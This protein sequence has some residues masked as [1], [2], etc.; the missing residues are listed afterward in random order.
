MPTTRQSCL[1]ELAIISFFAFRLA[2]ELEK[3]LLLI[4]SVF[5]PL[6]ISDVALDV[7]QS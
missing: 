1:A 6:L 7:E 5:T 3:K 4:I 2:L